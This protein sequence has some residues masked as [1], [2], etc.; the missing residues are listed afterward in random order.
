MIAMVK[1][2]YVGFS[3]AFLK[4]LL[5]NGE[6]QLQVVIADKYL[7]DEE[8]LGLCHRYSVPLFLAESD[9][10]ISDIMLC[11]V[12]Y[13]LIYKTKMIIHSELLKNYCFFNLH[14]GILSTNKGANPI[15]WTILLGEDRTALSLHKI[16]EK[17]DDGMLIAEYPVIVQPLDTTITLNMKMEEGFPVL[18]SQL[19]CY[20]K[21][22]LR[23]KPVFAG[24]YRRRIKEEDYLILATDNAEA[25]SRK[26]RSQAAYG[27]L[28]YSFEGR[29]FR[30]FS[31]ETKVDGKTVELDIAGYHCKGILE[32]H[33]KHIGG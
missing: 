25:V 19:N 26:I 24:G 28:K 22:T 32:D 3:C 5:G 15:V 31:D 8:F 29:M 16:N 17:I 6:Y 2:A 14:S 11:G 7:V 33:E 1:I 12:E 20:L 23:A 30:L 21:G 27:G 13:V 4:Y 9:K 18:L 10:E